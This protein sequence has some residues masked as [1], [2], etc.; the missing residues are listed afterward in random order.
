[1]VTDELVVGPLRRLGFYSK[2]IL[3]VG[4]KKV[5]LQNPSLEGKYKRV[6]TIRYVSTL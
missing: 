1:M 4:A 2:V 5:S 3:R 6:R